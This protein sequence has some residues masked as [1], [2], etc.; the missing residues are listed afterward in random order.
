[1][2]HT[3]ALRAHT[4]FT[5]DLIE[6]AQCQTLHACSRAFL[7]LLSPV[8]CSVFALAFVAAGLKCCMGAIWGSPEL[9][10]RPRDVNFVWAQR[11]SPSHLLLGCPMGMGTEQFLREGGYIDAGQS[12]AE[13]MA[14]IGRQVA[15]L[16]WP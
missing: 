3:V 12:V 1:M 7:L 11:D 8:Y 16:G 13:H 6:P 10:F 9:W 5:V 2:P 4:G 14:E 15:A